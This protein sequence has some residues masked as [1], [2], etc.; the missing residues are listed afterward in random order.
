MHVL[1]HL[2]PKKVF[3]FFEE[4]CKIPH[5][6]GNTKLISD[7]LVSFAKERNLE[8]YQ[9][10]LNNVI[11]IKN[12]SAGYE[13]SEPVIL[14]GHMD[15][16][17]EKAPDCQKDMENEGLDLA[18][19]GNIIYARGTTLGGD[20]GIAVAVMLAILDSDEIAHPRI[21]A[22]FTVDEEIGMLGAAGI[23]VSMLCGRRMLNLDSE[24]EG[25][26]TVSCAGGNI[27]N[28]SIPVARADFDGTAMQITVGGLKGGHSGIEIH[29][30]LGNSNILCARVLYTLSSK[31]QLRLESICGGLKDN[32]IPRETS[33][34]IV[35]T[36]P[37]TITSLCGELDTFLKE[38]YSQTD[39]GVFVKVE[40]CEYSM[41]MTKTA[42]SNILYFLNCLP[43]GVLAISK[44]IEGLVQTSS[45]LGILETAGTEV[46]GV[47]CV[48]SSV[49]EQKYAVNKQIKKIADLSGGGIEVTGNYSGWQYKKDSPLRELMTDIFTKQYGYPPKT[50][51]IHAGV[52]CGIF[53]GKLPDLDCISLGP[54]LT[55]IHTCREKLRIDSVGRLWYLV[56]E[57][58]KQMK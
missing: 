18:V 45:N 14:Q 27:V 29:K 15:M 53:A 12:P 41:P 19:D 31:A 51:A 2:E 38:S 25:V 16:V 6:S 55:E 49:D 40:E 37:D 48:R 44:E 22:I 21:E 42:T 52:E 46:T 24:V 39:P 33:A 10:S 35:T 26:F 1:D 36:D 17:C 9:D 58:L 43:N 3:H 32:A 30:G 4:I 8:F 50:E 11:I 13:A 57:T 56:L 7:W 34:K 28:F 54:N 5:G 20:D 47:I 23:D